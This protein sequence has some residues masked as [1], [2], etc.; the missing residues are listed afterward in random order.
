MFQQ[1]NIIDAG[2]VIIAGFALY[3][4]NPFALYFQNDDFI[5][6]PLSAEGVLLQHNTFRPVCDISIMFDYWLYGKQAWGYHLTNLLLHIIATIILFFF[7]RLVLRKYFNG[8]KTNAA[9]LLA[10]LLFFIY[11]SHSEAVFWIL[12]RSAIL[13]TIFSLLCLCCYIKRDES[14]KFTAGYILFF[15]VSLLTYESAWML[16]VFCFVISFV[17]ARQNKLVLRKEAIHFIIVIGIFLLYFFVRWNYIHEITG[18]YESAAFLNG[19][20][21]TLFKNFL[22]LIVRSFIPAFTD[23]KLLLVCFTICTIVIALS[24]FKVQTKVRKKLLVVFI[25]FLISLIPCCSLGIDTHGS[26]GERFLYF[27]VLIV[28]VLFAVLLSNISFKNLISPFVFSGLFVCHLIALFNSAENYR[29]V[30]NIN[31][32]LLTE[33]EKVKDKKLIYVESLPQAQ[34]GALI[35]RQGLPDMIK[36]MIPGSSIDSVIVCSQRSEIAPLQKPY[37]IIYGNNVSVNCKPDADLKADNTVLVKFTDTALYIS[38]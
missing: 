37:K 32:T 36:W 21:E 24:L 8:Y 20:A 15:I 29:F 35:L 25:C 34:Y 22:L 7:T 3:C 26:E 10:S 19:D 30:G 16:P 12:G 31:K 17:D 6:I 33:L 13:G 28:C 18:S 2:V 5:H 14:L 27:P 23:Y 11:G 4:Y 38:K 1:R 9:C